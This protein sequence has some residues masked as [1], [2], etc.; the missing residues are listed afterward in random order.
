MAGQARVAVIGA[1]LAGL[2]CAGALSGGV[3]AIVFEKSRGLGG[4]L[5]TRRPFGLDDPAGLDHGAPLAHVADPEARAALAAAG[6]VWEDGVVGTPGMSD[7]ARALAEGLD[8]RRETEIADIARGEDDF[9][10]M[11]KTGAPHGPFDAVVAAAPA[12]QTARLLGD[13]CPPHETDVAVRPTM[14]VMALFDAPLSAEAPP[15]IRPADGPLEL[16]VHNGAKPGRAARDGW[17]AHARE[18]WSDAHKDDEKDAIAA[19]LLP[20]LFEALGAPPRAPAYLAGHR[21]RYAQTTRAVG[22]A[23]WLSEDARLG[24]C[25]DWRLGATAGD[26]W[27]SGTLLGRAMIKALTA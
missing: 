19:A 27:R 12:A 5:A 17:V 10:L 2:A 3:Q 22:R 16:I 26:A 6:A 11:D 25:G 8:I 7:L 23:F 20:A 14:T 24:A 1:G 15:L 21:W 9:L 13:A 4:R 18:A